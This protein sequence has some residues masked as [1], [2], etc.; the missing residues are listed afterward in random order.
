MLPPGYALS[1]L[2][3]VGMPLPCFAMLIRFCF[4]IL[5]LNLSGGD[6]AAMQA[7]GKYLKAEPYQHSEAR[8]GH[9][10]GYK[11]KTVHTRVGSI[12]FSIPQVRE[13]GS[14]Q[15]RWRKAC[16]VNGLCF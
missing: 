10:N 3:A 14:I 6:H 13:A 5:C 7:D 9:A 15:K 2:V 1:W 4:Q 12:T 16:G 11:P 8:E